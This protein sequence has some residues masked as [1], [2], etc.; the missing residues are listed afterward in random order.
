MPER[1]ELVIVNP[2]SPTG[3]GLAG[4]IGQRALSS[5]V[6]LC[7]ASGKPLGVPSLVEWM[8]PETPAASASSRVGAPL[9]A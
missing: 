7:T 6:D 9:I 3:G 2:H 5:L 8:E 1:S 4:L